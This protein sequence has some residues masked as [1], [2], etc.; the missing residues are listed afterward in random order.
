MADLATVS[1]TSISGSAQDRTLRYGS[2]ATISAN[3]S[4]YNKFDIS[5]P[6]DF[7]KALIKRIT[8]ETRTAATLPAISEFEQAYL[9]HMRAGQSLM[10]FVPSKSYTTRSSP[11]GS[12][13]NINRYY[14]D[15][16]SPILVI[17]QD[18]IFMTMPPCDDD[19]TPTGDYNIIEME[20]SVIQY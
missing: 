6:T 5:V 10:N 13:P 3:N 20:F 12:A 8:V 2:A 1:L 17:P 15:Y 16:P 11:D 19:G 7:Q 4:D 9:Q 18:R 14:W